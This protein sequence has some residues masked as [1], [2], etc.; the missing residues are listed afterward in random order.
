M[1]KREQLINKLRELGYKY[2]RQSDRVEIY[3]RGT[4]RV[5]LPRRDLIPV[6]LAQ[7]LVRQAGASE[8]DA[9]AFIRA[10]G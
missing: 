6:A 10:C 9:L 3:A 8:S 4:Q 2:K 7:I 5:L 1:I